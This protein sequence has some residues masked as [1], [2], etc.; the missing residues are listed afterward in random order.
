MDGPRFDRIARALASGVP[1][2]RL[3]GGLAAGLA[4]AGLLGPRAAGAQAVACDLVAGLNGANETD[5]RGTFGLGDPDGR[6]RACVDLR[7]RE[8]CWEITAARIGPVTAAH[9]HRGTRRQAGPVVVDFA[10]QLA[11]CTA[12]ARALVDEIT[13]DPAGFY[14]NVHTG[15]FPGGAIR[16]QLRPP[17]RA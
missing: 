11:G 1:R 9:I 14:V 13:A 6:G 3:L 5:G 17:H 16:G 4:G 15:R 7:R 10:G 8:V 12:V 2:R